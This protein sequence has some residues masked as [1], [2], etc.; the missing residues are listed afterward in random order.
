MNSMY[1]LNKIQLTKNISTQVNV[2]RMHTYVMNIKRWNQYLMYKMNQNEVDIY[3]WQNTYIYIFFL[4][5]NIVISTNI[6]FLFLF[7]FLFYISLHLINNV[8]I[9]SD[10]Q[11]SDLVI[12]ESILFQIIFLLGAR[13]RYSAHDKGHEEGGSTYAKAGSSLRS[14]PGT[15]WAST[16]ITRA[17]LLY[18]FVLLPTPLT[19]RGA[20]PHHL[21]RRRS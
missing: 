10:V 8:V 6:L 11:Q 19:L 21:F 9:A 3:E 7:N 20:V 12:H 5:F 13:V 18:Y 2:K 15:P 1:I 16:P 14:P 4:L 17:C